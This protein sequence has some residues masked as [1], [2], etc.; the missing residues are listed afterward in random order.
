MQELLPIMITATTT[1]ITA[2]TAT[3]VSWLNAS[4]AK[5]TYKEKLAEA[6]KANA[7]LRKS[8]IENAFIICPNCGTKIILKNQDIHTKEI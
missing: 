6:E 3:I 1:I 8:I 2:L 4:K 5:A 7:E